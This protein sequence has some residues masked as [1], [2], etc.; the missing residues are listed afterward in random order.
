MKK[1]SL[2]IIMLLLVL[3]VPFSAL[4][5][6]EL[7]VS[8]STT[9]QKRI[10]EPAAEAIE[11][12]TGIKVTVRGINSGEGLKELREGKVVASISSS[13]LEL[14]LRK[15]GLPNDGTY[16]EHIIVQDVIVPIVNN[17]NSVSKLTWRQLSDINT[18]K[19]TDWKEVGGPSLPIV[20]VTSQPT[21]ATRLVFQE[22]VMDKAPYVAGARE[23]KSTRQEVGL[24]AKY[25]GGIGAV[26]EG[27]VAQ[28]P[29]QVKTVK[30][31]AITRPL[32]FITKGKPNSQVQAVLDFL[33]TPEAQKNFQ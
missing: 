6:E 11:K 18:G 28:N 21:A 22:I 33:K 13:P 31:D 3:A 9:V 15:A 5:A 14:L 23:V 29:G 32:S 1:A 19:I 24:V 2:S 30:T 17:G 10:L 26:S 12:A 4:A 8:G 25:K 16:V 27:F 7:A 20:V